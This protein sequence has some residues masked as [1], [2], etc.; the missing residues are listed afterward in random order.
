MLPFTSFTNIKLTK[1]VVEPGRDITIGVYETGYGFIIEGDS[2]NYALFVVKSNPN[3]T[4][5]LEFPIFVIENGGIQL[6]HT[7]G[8]LCLINCD[9]LLKACNDRASENTK[10]GYFFIPYKHQ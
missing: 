6:R 2:L 10:I 9:G 3:G 4:E 8:T 7:P 5:P 1:K